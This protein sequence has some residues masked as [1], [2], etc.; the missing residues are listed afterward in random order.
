MSEWFSGLGYEGQLA[1]W[2]VASFLLYVLASQIAWQSQWMFASEQ[3]P[4]QHDTW[5]RFIAQLRD[6]PLL[7]FAEQALRFL[8]YLGIPFTAAINGL[9]RADL[10]GISGTDWVDGQS[11]QGFLWEDWAQGIGLAAMAILAM[12]GVWFA[13][14]LLSGRS[15]LTPATERSPAPT[16]QRLLDLIYDQIHWAFYRS[17]PI[18]WLVDPYWGTFAGLGLVLLEAMLNPALRWA[19]KDS[20]T[21]GPILIRLG[22]AWISALLFLVTRNIWLTI[23]AHLALLALLSGRRSDSYALADESAH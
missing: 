12:S 1:I 3:Y 22:M 17:G 21:A 15:G 6:H 7:P 18:L 5:G 19:L 9:L 16:W 20:H 13:G 2:L 4:D 14:R 10:M 11:A 23:A 8:Y